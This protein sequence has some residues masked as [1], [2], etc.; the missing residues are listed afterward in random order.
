M[1]N[2]F[3]FHAHPTF[4]S[5]LTAPTDKKRT[6]PWRIFRGKV[7]QIVKP[8]LRSQASFGQTIKGNVRIQV[9]PIVPL[10]S[11]F[12]ELVL[13]KSVAAKFLSVSKEFIRWI[14]AGQFSYNDLFWMEYE[15]LCQHLN[16]RGQR[17][18]VMR[19]IEDLSRGRKVIN[20]VLS[21]EG[22]HALQ[23]GPRTHEVKQPAQYFQNLK[24]LKTEE[25]FSIL[26]MTLTHLTWNNVC[27]HCYGTRISGNEIFKPNPHVLGMSKVGHQLIDL[28]YDVDEGKR[29]LIDIKHMSLLARRELYAYRKKKGYNHIPLIASHAGATGFSSHDL[30]GYLQPNTYYAGKNNEYIVVDY[31]EVPGIGEGKRDC[32]TFNPWS[33][34]L[35]DEDIKAIINSGGLIGLS[36][37]QRI[38]GEGRN[39]EEF[40]LYKEF[41]KVLDHNVPS[42]IGQREEEKDDQDELVAE[43]KEERKVPAYKLRR[44]HRKHLRHLANNLLHMV[45]TGGKK[46]WK[47]IC[48][49]SDFDG[50]IDPINSCLHAGALPLLERDLHKIT[51]EMI[52]EDLKKNPGHEYHITNLR[53]QI[54]DVMYNNGERFLKRYYSKSYLKTGK[55]KA[56]K[57]AI[58]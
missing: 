47:H 29:I 35:Y 4:K 55:V 22:S 36:L 13:I 19:S 41:T 23:D 15:H 6:N 53:A 2:I 27:N 11:G 10:E 9:M 49:G 48:I 34:N 45:R 3:D 24:K 38:L 12:S 42:P 5:F 51:Q 40:F 17:V 32:T 43:D 46:A 7:F 8:I 16:F 18:N 52:Q 56:K 14:N 1:R 58:A 33:I 28:A 54:R 31:K 30:F 37:D 57:K 50:L 39:Q 44:T 20:L 25:R 21:V 26:Y